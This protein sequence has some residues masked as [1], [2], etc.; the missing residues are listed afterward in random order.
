MWWLDEVDSR[1]MW[2]GIGTVK[3]GHGV[4]GCSWETQCGEWG[5]EECYYGLG[6]KK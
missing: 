3:R 5:A 1:E 2:G 6:I 4:E